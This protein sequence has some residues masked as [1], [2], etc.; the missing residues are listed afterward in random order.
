MGDRVQ[1]GKILLDQWVGKAA[2]LEIHRGKQAVLELVRVGLTIQIA[3]I[4]LLV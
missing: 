4:I 2:D 1:I 3:L